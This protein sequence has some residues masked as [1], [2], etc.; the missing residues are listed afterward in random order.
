M[1]YKNW[2]TII[3][4]LGMSAVILGAF[5]AHALKS[6]LNLEQL[7]SYRVGIQYHFYHTFA[8]AFA[9]VLSQ[10]LDSKILKNSLLFFFLGIIFFSGSIYLLACRE[11]IGLASWKWL[12]PITP[13]GGLC[14][15]IAWGLLGLASK[16]I[17]EK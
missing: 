7:D 4:I 2:L 14:F 9:F 5:G 6:R 13:L 17:I 12:G 11:I 10:W 1:K 3:A 8:M 15:I 16:K